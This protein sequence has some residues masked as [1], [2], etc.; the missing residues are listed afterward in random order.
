[1]SNK[2]LESQVIN[3][4]QGALWDYNIVTKTL[5]DVLLDS[6][7]HESDFYLPLYTDFMNHKNI[8]RQ[9]SDDFTTIA[10]DVTLAYTNKRISATTILKFNAMSSA[11]SWLYLAFESLNRIYSYEDNDQ[12]SLEYQTFSTHF[13][14]SFSAMENYPID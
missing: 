9:W 12:K 4:T 11:F 1:M 7:V 2:E 3:Y 10:M 14:R 6:R 13:E 8:V 5:S